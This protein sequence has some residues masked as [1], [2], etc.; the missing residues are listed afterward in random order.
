[1]TDGTEDTIVCNSNRIQSI[2]AYSDTSVLSSNS[3]NIR[4][5]SVFAVIQLSR[6]YFGLVENEYM[7]V[8]IN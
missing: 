6:V 3:S 5:T 8:C 2:K 7:N 4:V 1:M